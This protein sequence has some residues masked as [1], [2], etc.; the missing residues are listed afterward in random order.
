MWK[1]NPAQ[2]TV[3]GD[4]AFKGVKIKVK[5]GPEGHH[6]ETVTQYDKCP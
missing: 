2:G 3:F 6:G 4:Q 5:Q 1:P